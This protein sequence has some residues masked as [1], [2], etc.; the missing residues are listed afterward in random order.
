MAEIW[1]DETRWCLACGNGD[2]KATCAECGGTGWHLTDAGRG[3]VRLLDALGVE[4]EQTRYLDEEPWMQTWVLRPPV[5]RE[6]EDGELRLVDGTEAG[7]PLVREPNE[8]EALLR[9]LQQNFFP[10]SDDLIVE[11]NID[12]QAHVSSSED[13]V[14]ESGQPLSSKPDTPV[15]E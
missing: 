11:K 13:S 12:S 15:P 2:E 14:L 7:V 6:D 1:G 5:L 3:L 9:L 8:D 4:R 10:G